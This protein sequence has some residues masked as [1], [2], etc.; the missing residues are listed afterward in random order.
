MLEFLIFDQIIFNFFGHVI[1]LSNFLLKLF[2]LTDQVLS[3]PSFSFDFISS[4]LGDFIR[5]I[6]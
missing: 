5:I 6:H 2:D 1:L 4:M 3:L